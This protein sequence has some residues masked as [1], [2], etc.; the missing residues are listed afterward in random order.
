MAKPLLHNQSI[1]D[2]TLHHC[3]KFEQLVKLA[4]LN[5]ISITDVLPVGSLIEVP[6]DGNDNDIV[7]FFKNKNHIPA[8]SAGQIS[9]NQNTGIDYWT[10]ENDFIVQ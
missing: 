4:V 1:I 2:F 8:N 3:G 5:K 9:I 7:D 10:I 6:T